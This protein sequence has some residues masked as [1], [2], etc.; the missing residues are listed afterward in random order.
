VTV[1][2]VAVG[3][4]GGNAATET[5][6]SHRWP[7]TSG[8]QP[9]EATPPAPLRRRPDPARI[10][11]RRFHRGTV[12][13]RPS[14]SRP[15]VADLIRPVSR[16]I[17]VCQVVTNGRR[18]QRD[19]LPGGSSC[20]RVRGRAS[21][22]RS[23]VGRTQPGDEATAEASVTLCR[24]TVTPN[25]TESIIFELTPVNRPV[26]VGDQTGHACY[27]AAFTRK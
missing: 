21:A 23:H 24:C 4:R 13:R 7:R 15:M 25:T 5:D 3:L 12:G 11:L 9:H 19:A 6:R 16:F 18:L 10:T 22:S 20:R 26:A 8:G 2:S 14:T 17:V 1:V 27:G